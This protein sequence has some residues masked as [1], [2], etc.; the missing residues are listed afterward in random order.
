MATGG[1]D[2]DTAGGDDIIADLLSVSFSRRLFDEKMDIIKKGCPTPKRLELHQPAKAGYVHHYQV[3][4]FG[5]DTLGF[6]TSP[7]V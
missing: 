1:N 5:N 3:Q 6:A 4:V 7:L 2:I